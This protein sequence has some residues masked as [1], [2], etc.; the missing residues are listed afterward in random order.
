MR[1]SDKP[2]RNLKELELSLKAGFGNNRTFSSFEEARDAVLIARINNSE[3]ILDFDQR[4]VGKRV[5]FKLKIREKSG[6]VDIRS[7]DCSV[8]QVPTLGPVTVE[9][10]DDDNP[11]TPNILLLQN[12]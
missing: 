6:K 4:I 9:H 12:N 5:E 3:C 2:R 8:N 10:D 11:S 7:G 1:L